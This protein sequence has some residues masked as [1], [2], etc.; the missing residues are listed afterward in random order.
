M[1]ATNLRHGVLQALSSSDQILFSKFGLGTT[2][3]FPFECIHHAFELHARNQP[4]SIAV[5][6]MDDKTT[7]AELDHQANSVASHLRKLGVTPDSRVG[8]VVERSISMVIG[9]LAI[10]KT[11]AAYIPLD[12]NDTSNES[13]NHA[14]Q[15]SGSTIALIQSRFANRITTVM[16]LILEDSI[17][18]HPSSVH[19]RKPQDLAAGEDSAC[20]IY[21]QDSSYRPKGIDLTHKNIVNLVCISPGNLGMC[22]GLRVSQITNISSALAV[23]EILGSLCNGSTLVLGGTS[24]REWNLVMKMVDIVIA[25]PTMLS[26]YNPAEH[27][28]IKVVA[29]AGDR[30]YSQGLVNIWARFVK[31]Y[32]CRGHTETTIVSTMQLHSP[33]RNVGPSKVIPNNSIYILDEKRQPVEMGGAGI[34]WIGGVGVSRGYVNLSRLS[35]L[36]YR[37]DPFLNNGMSMFDTGELA[38]WRPDGSLEYAD[39]GGWQV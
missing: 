3:E 9:I 28:N 10:L 31:F 2:I 21:A 18:P 38:R 24:I 5:Q 30:N 36:K 6:D 32:T 35:S 11:G 7:Y 16:T 14:L 20:I 8:L 25:T 33:G 27:R 37:Y 34:V 23:W 19:C 13:L 1:Q 26:L 15:D 29:A 4:N 22:Q 17:C 12:G 39:E